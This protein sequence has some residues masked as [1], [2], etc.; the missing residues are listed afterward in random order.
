MRDFGIPAFAPQLIQF[1]SHMRPDLAT[2]LTEVYHFLTVVGVRPP[3]TFAYTILRLV[4]TWYAGV[5]IRH[6]ISWL[7]SRLR[8]TLSLFFNVSNLLCYRR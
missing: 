1:N 2:E 7:Y 5:H 3:Q 4:H 6:L 8:F